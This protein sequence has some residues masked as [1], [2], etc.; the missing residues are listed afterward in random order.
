MTM[1]ETEKGEKSTGLRKGL[2]K[3]RSVQDCGE[4]LRSERRK[5][6]VSTWQG[7]ILNSSSHFKIIFWA[8]V[9][10]ILFICLSFIIIYLYCNVTSF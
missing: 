4:G 3:E 2:R 8:A 9:G 10:Y 1:G 7:N 5:K 6:Y